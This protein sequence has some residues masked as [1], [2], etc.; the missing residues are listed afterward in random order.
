MNPRLDCHIGDTLGARVE[1]SAHGN[2]LAGPSQA[3][4]QA[5]LG[6][7]PALGGKVVSAVGVF[8]VQGQGRQE[9][10]IE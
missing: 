5:V 3:E 9:P 6:A 4:A 2:I 10:L 8:R 1:V 7:H